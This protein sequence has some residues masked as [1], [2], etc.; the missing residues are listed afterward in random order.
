MGAVQDK[1]QSYSNERFDASL[2][3]EEAQATCHRQ[4]SHHREERITG[5]GFDGFKE[6][7]DRMPHQNASQGLC[8][9]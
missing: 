4:R 8:D 1:C 5:V 6:T 2:F 9:A 7:L 3:P